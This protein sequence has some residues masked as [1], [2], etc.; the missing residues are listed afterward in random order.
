MAQKKYIVGEMVEGHRY[1]KK[2]TKDESR[3]V[4][5]LIDKR[6]ILRDKKANAA[7]F[8]NPELKFNCIYFLIGYEHDD[9]DNTIEKMYVGQAGIRDNGESV[10][11]RLNEHA[12]LG[13]D[14][15]KYLDKWTDIVVVTNEKGL[16]GATELDALEHIFWSLIPVGNRYNSQKPTCTGADL[17]KCAD[18]VKQIKE[19]LDYLGY[20]MFENKSSEEIK[21]DVKAVADAKSD[22]PI[23]LDKGT[24]KI[25]NI[26]TPKAVINRMLDM[27]PERVW[28]D[29]TVFLDMACKDGGYLRAIHDRLVDMPELLEKYDNDKLALS[30]HILTEQ[31]H[32][33]ALNQNS[34]SVTVK[35]L[36]GFGDNIRVFPRYTDTLK[37]FSVLRKKKSAN[38][39]TKVDTAIV[40]AV[41]AYI[42]EEFKK[43]MKIDVVIG[44]PPYQDADG[45]SSVYPYF[46]ESAVDISDI[47]CMI[48]RD[49]WLAGMAFEDMRNHMNLHGKVE[50]IVHYPVVSEV[51]NNVGVAVAYFL[52][53]RGYAGD[54][55]YKRIEN[56]KEISNRQVDIDRFI[57]SDIAAGIVNKVNAFEE[58]ADTFNSRSY[59]FMDQ[60]KRLE[61]LDTS[62]I[63][64]QYYNVAVI[65]NK[66]HTVYT[67]IGFFTNE[68]EVRKYKVLCGV[69]IN[70][71]REDSPGNVLT[72]IKAIYPNVVASETW[73]LVASFDN[74][75]ETVNCKKYIQTKFV[76]FLANL[77]VN[78][79]ATVTRN[80][81]K[82]IPLQDFTEN[83][84]IDWTQTVA[85]I[86]RQLF[87]KYGLTEAEIAYINKIIKP[88]DDL[89]AQ[90]AMAAYV[91]REIQKEM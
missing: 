65:A 5:F 81:F 91:N 27:L 17:E 21:A 80:A 71:A 26:T 50:E 64:D 41:Q 1:C 23:D 8:N 45:K 14:P 39:N 77:T 20:S 33:I 37:G 3:T 29:E 82:F 43:E 60:R 28:S 57:T 49:N 76:R 30:R 19:Y 4:A 84:D 51:F 59:P 12:Y 34:R 22:L 70:E 85:G 35:K 56:G 75:A 47:T 67:N 87:S 25:P 13:N 48:T 31:I 62:V 68:D 18:A 55:I 66:E 63:N 72:N 36:S 78:V 90:D 61:K 69:K 53:S 40:N 38:S 83:S 9:C 58:W 46:I 86:D 7:S 24:T 42:N 54:T 6:D 74:E 44:N 73:S 16:W 11:D 15:A 52:W 10:L 79:K 32:G 2:L 89:T 88:M